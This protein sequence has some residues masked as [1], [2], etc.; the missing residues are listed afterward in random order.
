MQAVCQRDFRGIQSV[1]NGI[2]IKKEVDVRVLVV[3]GSTSV[4]F[5]VN[6]AHSSSSNNPKLSMDTRQQAASAPVESITDFPN[7]VPQRCILFA[8]HLAGHFWAHPICVSNHHFSMATC[9]V[10]PRLESDEP[11]VDRSRSI[12]F[13]SLIGFVLKMRTLENRKSNCTI[14]GPKWRQTLLDFGPPNGGISW[15][16]D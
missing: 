11:G 3:L 15:P 9:R 5:I 6:R 8:L 1:S 10:A 4:H 13:M 16:L 12:Q 2:S 7:A 14:W